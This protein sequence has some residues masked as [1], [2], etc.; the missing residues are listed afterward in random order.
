MCVCVC[1]YAGEQ[2]LVV[3]EGLI[4]DAVNLLS[5]V[6]RPTL[7]TLPVYQVTYCDSTQAMPTLSL[8][9][10]LSLSLSFSLSHSLCLF[11]HYL[12]QLS[13]FETFWCEKH[14]W[15]YLMCL[16]Y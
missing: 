2:P 11:Q 4:Q 16:H 14:S 3:V 12:F 8:S 1:V 5:S 10:S 15:V 6:Q 7:D 13:T 9:P